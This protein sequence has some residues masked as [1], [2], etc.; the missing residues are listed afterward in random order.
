MCCAKPCRMRSSKAVAAT[1]AA[2]RAYYDAHRTS[3]RQTG[4][5]HVWTIQVAAER[6][7]ESALGAAARAA[8]HSM[9]SRGS[10]RPTPR[11]RRRAGT[12]ARGAGVAS[13]AA[14]QGASRRRRAGQVSNPVAGS[15]RLVPAHGDGRTSGAHQPFSEVRQAIVSELTRRKRFAALEAGWTRPA[16]RLRYAT[17]TPAVSPVGAVA[18]YTPRRQTTTGGLPCGTLSSCS[19]SSPCSS[20]GW[21]RSTTGSPSTSTT[22][23]ARPMRCRCSGCPELIAALVFIVG[24]VAAWFAKSA[25]TGSRR[26]LE[27]ELQST[28]ARLREA[29]ALP[30]AAAPA[31]AGA[32][33]GGRGRDRRRR[34]GGGHRGGD[35][36]GDRRRRRGS[37][38][39]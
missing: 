30:R 16:T 2:T 4:V 25:M 26:K 5:R 1:A 10:S 22:W 27:A 18:C 7:A 8:V 23:P 31:A 34:A 32:R 38:R 33:R 17:L 37:R 36:S 15:G 3:F 35:R 21:A 20:S 11:P 28:Y 13:G 24:L 19:S 9:R 12:W 29:E 6:I 14:A 39:P